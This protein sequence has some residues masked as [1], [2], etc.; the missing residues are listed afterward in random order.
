MTEVSLCICSV[1]L[2][3][4]TQLCNLESAGSTAAVPSV[5]FEVPWYFFFGPET[6]FKELWLCPLIDC[7]EAVYTA[8]SLKSARVCVSDCLFA[9]R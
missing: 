5:L 6:L 1:D 3:T 9:L 4:F 8:Q 2:Y 7:R